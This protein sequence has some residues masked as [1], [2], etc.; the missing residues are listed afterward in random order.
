MTPDLLTRLNQL[1]A[2]HEMWTSRDFSYTQWI[3]WIAILS[4]FAATISVAFQKMPKWAIAI[5]AAI[6]ALSL[7]VDKTFRYRERS[8]WHELYSVELQ[9]LRD[10]L[11]INHAKEADIA[12]NLRKLRTDMQ[13]RW[14]GENVAAIPTAP[15][16]AIQ[17][18]TSTPTPPPATTPPEKP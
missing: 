6:P 14:P 18:P 3:L 9:N 10:D 4:S 7:M 17:Q 13:A 1:I 11:E 15:T 2:H 8:L 5:L 12:K 16:E